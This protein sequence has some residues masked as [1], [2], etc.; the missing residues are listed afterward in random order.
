VH[1]IFAARGCEV[2]FND[3]RD[4]YTGSMETLSAL[5]LIT[6]KPTKPSNLCSPLE[7]DYNND[8][9]DDDDDQ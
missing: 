8:D 7:V 2:I 6:K 4:A 3:Q 5:L 1:R 9:D